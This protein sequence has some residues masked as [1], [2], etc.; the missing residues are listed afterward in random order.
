MSSEEFVSRRKHPRHNIGDCIS[1]VDVA[2]GQ[3]LGRVAN[4]SLEGL[5]LVNNQPLN[6]DCI[7]QLKLIIDGSQIPGAGY[8]LREVIIG[9]DCLWASPAKSTSASA[10][11]S[12]CQIIDIS[13]SDFEAIKQLIEAIAE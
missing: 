6:A 7:Y 1:V 2:S 8:D 9:V 13:E 10:Y 12:G 11:W 4:L 5:M 3:D